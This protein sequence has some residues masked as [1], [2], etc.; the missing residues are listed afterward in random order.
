ML[1]RNHGS[2][3]NSA[4]SA[5]L[6]VSLEKAHVAGQQADFAGQKADFPAF[7]YAARSRKTMEE[8]NRLPKS[9]FESKRRM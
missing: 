8:S 5:L 2:L 7:E 9:T 4:N 3:D 1:F 6:S